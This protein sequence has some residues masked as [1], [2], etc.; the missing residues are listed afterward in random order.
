MSK[1]QVKK[2]SSTDVNR[3]KKHP[4]VKGSLISQI[5]DPEQ[6]SL[7]DTG[8]SNITLGQYLSESFNSFNSFAIEP[9]KDSFSIQ[10]VP[11]LADIESIDPEQYYD[12]G[13]NVAKAKL[14]IR[15]RNSGGKDVIGVS[16]RRTNPAGTGG[17]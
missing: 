11:Q 6:L 8:I 9:T 13:S 10:E 4:A 14:I 17:R 2:I 5:V 7:Y 1:N 15:I 16:V 12:A 3:V